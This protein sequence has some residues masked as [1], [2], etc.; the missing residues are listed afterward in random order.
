VN[1]DNFIYLGKY[2]NIS[3]NEQL[4]QNDFNESKNHCLFR[5]FEIN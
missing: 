3:E 4:Y 1:C 2:V 5:C